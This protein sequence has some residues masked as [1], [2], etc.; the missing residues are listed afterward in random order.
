MSK[1]PPGTKPEDTRAI[2]VEIEID[3]SVEEV[4]PYLATSE[5]LS[6]WYVGA[7]FE[8][9]RAG[10]RCTLTFGPGMVV[11]AHIHVYEVHDRVRLGPPPGVDSPRVEEYSVRAK[12]GGGCVVRVTNWGFGEGA[13]WDVEFE[14]VK[15]G[16]GVFL[17]TLKEVVEKFRQFGKPICVQ[18][19]SVSADAA[20]AW[21]KVEAMLGDKVGNGF[22][23]GQQ[24]SLGGAL[25]TPLEGII[26]AAGEREFTMC[27]QTDDGGLLFYA[28]VEQPGPMA[29][30]GLGMRFFGA[31]KS[32]AATVEASWGAWFQKAFPPPTP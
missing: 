20:G 18:L 14:S 21:A 29:M 19:L 15:K 27:H 32:Q 24:V 4:W 5:G 10:V 23:E 22:S 31:H 28:T 17:A 9:E 3:A 25:G 7:E 12:E 26:T 30:I 1:F 8:E 2:E 13:D 16:W 6:S 11:P